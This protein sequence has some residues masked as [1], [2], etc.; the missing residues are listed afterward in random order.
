MYKIPLLFVTKNILS[1]KHSKNK[2]FPNVH[3][4]TIWLKY[5]LMYILKINYE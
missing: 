3:K 5:T 2:H 4:L 1:I